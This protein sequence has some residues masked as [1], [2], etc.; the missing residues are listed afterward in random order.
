VPDLG[1]IAD[2]LP[3]Y[4]QL[5][6]D[7]EGPLWAHEMGPQGG[8]ELNLIVRGENYGWPVVSTSKRPVASRSRSYRL[9]SGN[10]GNQ[11]SRRTIQLS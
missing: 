10:G 3:I 1:I 4:I 5:A 8:D 9:V 7:S 6:F 2:I 11:D